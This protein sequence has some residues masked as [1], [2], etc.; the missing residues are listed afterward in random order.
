MLKISFSP[1]EVPEQ[2]TL[3]LTVADKQQLGEMGGKLDQ[4]LGGALRRAMEDSYF[5]GAKEQTLTVAAP[6]KA[7][8][9]RVILVGIG[10]PAKADELVW[11][12]VGGA[13]VAAHSG[14]EGQATLLIDRH[15][16]MA[17]APSAAAANAALGARLRAYRFDKYRTKLKPEQKPS[18]KSLSIGGEDAT[19]ARKLYSRMDKVADGVCF[20]RDLVSEP[21]NGMEEMKWD[22]AGAGAVIGAMRALAGRKAKANVVGV[23]GLVENMP[24]GTAQRPGDIVTSMSGQTIEV[25][26]TDAEGRLVLADAIWYAQ[27]T[28][29]P[30]CVIDLATLTGAVIVSLGNEFAG[31][32]T[33]EDSLG[34]QLLKAGKDVDEPLWRLPMGEAFDRDI[35]SPAADMKNIGPKGEA[36]SIVG[37]QF[38]YRFVKKG[39]PWAHLDIAG[40]AWTNKD[41]PVCAKGA[42]AYGV[43]LLDRFISNVVEE[44]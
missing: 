22:M 16:D 39:V 42:T 5:T 15:K 43:R 18:L 19:N 29:N 36:G 13:V 9:A 30:R 17:S 7:E 12:R 28:Y 2:G 31:L 20:T 11:Q 24:S 44:E 38:V 41:R 10:E 32:F 33:N 35:D 37:A 6:G 23:V 40:T 3:I 27:E 1:F 4:K 21:A 14:K 8:L 34:E 25:L 26:N